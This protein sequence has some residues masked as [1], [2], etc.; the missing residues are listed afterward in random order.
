[1]SRLNEKLAIAPASSTFGQECLKIGPLVL[2]DE[3]TKREGDPK[4][5]APAPERPYVAVAST[6]TARQTLSSVA[7]AFP[8]CAG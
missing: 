2:Q 7:A 6:R 8:E 3:L 1:M 5:A 4:S